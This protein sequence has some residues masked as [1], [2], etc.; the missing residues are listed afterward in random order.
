MSMGIQDE[1]GIFAAQAADARVANV[2]KTIQALEPTDLSETQ[3]VNLAVMIMDKVG[4]TDGRRL[5]EMLTSQIY[6]EPMPG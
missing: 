4:V 1:M 2:S 5:R 6:H 3:A